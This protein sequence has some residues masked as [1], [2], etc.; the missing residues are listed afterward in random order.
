MED[1]KTHSFHPPKAQSQH[2]SEL[3]GKAFWRQLTSYKIFSK[4]RKEREGV[5]NCIT[6][7]EQLLKVRGFDDILTS[8]DLVTEV[9]EI[10]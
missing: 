8:P 5:G 2:S 6:G 9:L 3:K 4:E 7:Q 10:I 1:K